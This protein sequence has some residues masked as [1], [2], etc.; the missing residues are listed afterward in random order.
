[1]DGVPLGHSYTS[2]DACARGATRRQ[3][4]SD[5]VRLS[6]GLYVSRAVDLDLVLRCRAWARV[7]P[8]DAAFGLGTAVQLFGGPVPEPEPVHVVLRPRRV[9]PQRADLAVHARALIDDDVVQ[10]HGLRITSGAQTF[11]D[12]APRL[13]PAELVAVGDALVRGGA[14][15]P[16]DLARRAGAREQGARCRAGP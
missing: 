1:M 12:L 13:P 11:L 5:G 8:S 3:V 15:T 10:L 7:L 9:L 4:R 2:R 16:T 14:L 6:R